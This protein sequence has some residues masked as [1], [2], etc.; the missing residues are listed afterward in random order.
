MQII[1]SRDEFYSSTDA[2]QEILLALG[3]EGI[4]DFKYLTAEYLI[5][6]SD[7]IWMDG[8]DIV[9]EIPED[10]FH[11]LMDQ[12]RQKSSL[13]KANV[14]LIKRVLHMAEMLLNSILQDAKAAVR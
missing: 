12:L 4:P 7:Q 9:F 11:L 6:C 2:V 3:T 1:L 13:I 14:S 5:D 10:K 8:E